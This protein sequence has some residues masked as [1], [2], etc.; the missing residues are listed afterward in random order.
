MTE[1][2]QEPVPGQAQGPEQIGF[3]FAEIVAL[4]NL[5][6]ANVGSTEAAAASAA[7]LRVQDEMDN[8]TVISAGTSSLVARGLATVDGDGELTVAGPVAAVTRAL[9]MAT[10]RIQ[11]DLLMPGTTDNV[12]S[13]DSEDISILL[14][15]RSFRSW[16]VMARKP[17]ISTAEANLFIIRKHFEDHETAGAGIRN[18]DSES[19]GR[20]LIKRA[21]N[22]W[23][24][25]VHHADGAVDDEVT[26]LDDAALY[27]RIQRVR[28][29]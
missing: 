24:V 14:Q 20:V 27:E 21:D 5:G 23:T 7:A 13:I 11:I 1:T 6:G 29:G 15:P 18:L 8:A 22:A 19:G 10:S 12:L 17:D 16:F 2:A 9:A 4:L 25:A 3:G 28:E 26:G